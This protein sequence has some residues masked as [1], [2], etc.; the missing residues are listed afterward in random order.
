MSIDLILSEF[1]SE[2]GNLSAVQVLSEVLS[3]P[4][5]VSQQGVFGVLP[6]GKTL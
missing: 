4:L 5:P 3:S 2:I 1:E 6:A